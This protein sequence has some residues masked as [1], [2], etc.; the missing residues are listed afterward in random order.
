VTSLSAE[1]ADAAALLRLWRARWEIENRTFW[2]RDVVFGEDR[3]RIRTGR[4]A[5]NMSLLKNA[6]INYLRAGKVRNITAALR[7]NAVQVAS[8]FA[9]LRLPTF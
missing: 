4:A 6:A 7:K 8:L 5:E 1:Q 9:K 3:S 2:V